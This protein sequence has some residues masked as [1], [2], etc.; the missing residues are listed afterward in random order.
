MRPGMLKAGAGSAIGESGRT[1]VQTLLDNAGRST[2]GVVGVVVGAAILVFGATGLFVHL[3]SA[4]NRV[5]KVEPEPGGGLRKFLK[6]R[7]IS[8]IAILVVALLLLASLILSAITTAA[9]EWSGDFLGG[10]TWVPSL[11]NSAVSLVLLTFLFAFVY[12][13]LLMPRSNGGKCGMAPF[14]LPFSL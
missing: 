10:M 7:T 6:Q 4:I 1:L 14:S 8:F 9:A 2:A 5:W 13:I 12:K 11:L 3:Q